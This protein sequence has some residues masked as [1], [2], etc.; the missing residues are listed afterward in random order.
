MGILNVTPDSFYDGGKYSSKE[1]AISQFNKLVDEGADIVDIGGESTRPG[2]K[3]ISFQEEIKRVIPVIKAIPRKNVLISL[4]S[5]KP[6]VM[7]K[8]V[9]VGI[10]LVNDVSGLRYSKKTFNILKKNKLPFVIMHSISDP[11]NMQKDI[12]Y[13]DVLLD[14]YDFFESQIEKCKKNSINLSN[15]IL[16]PGIGFG[17]TVKQNLK[18]ISNIA[19][20]HSLGFPIL[21]GTSRKSFIGKLS[22]NTLNNERLGGSIATVLYGLTQGV[23]I[24]RVHDVQ[25]TIQAIKIFSKI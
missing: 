22:R 12:K 13:D 14:V 23:Q 1:S 6:E 20:F 7:D 17:K 18:L 3:K 24:F 11:Q 4:D 19:L 10:N 2:A 16:D 21:L 15:I 9:K 8:A 5:R 25:E